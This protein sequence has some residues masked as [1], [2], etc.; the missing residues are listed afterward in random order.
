MANVMNFVVAVAFAG[1]VRPHEARHLERAAAEVVLPLEPSVVCHTH[2][3]SNFIRY[4]C[5]ACIPSSF[6][7]K[8]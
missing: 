3:P 1:E 6:F 4:L 2:F 8:S 5:L 7:G